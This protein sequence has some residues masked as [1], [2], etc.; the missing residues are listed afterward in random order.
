M[1]AYL[2][3]KWR[4]AVS[5]VKYPLDGAVDVLAA[6]NLTLTFTEPM[7]IV[8]T[9]NIVIRNQDTG[10]IFETIAITSGQVTGD[11]TNT[12]TINP[13]VNFSVDTNYVV[14]FPGAE[15]QGASTG[16][17]Y[18]GTPAG[19]EWNFYVP[20]P[21]DTSFDPRD[22][23]GLEL[24]LDASDASTITSSGTRVT[25]WDDNLETRGMLFK[26]TILIDDSGVMSIGGKNVLMFRDRYMELTNND[27]VKET[28]FQV[29]KYLQTL[30]TEKQP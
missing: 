30:E 2:Q 11:G 6:D 22:I 17:Y 16:Y 7:N 1:I 8:G 18:I 23:A 19:D 27:F 15:L 29:F 14:D 5:N 9:G 20:D 10:A 24:W 12:I 21:L 13:S 26:Q 4:I 25:N 28:I 3:E